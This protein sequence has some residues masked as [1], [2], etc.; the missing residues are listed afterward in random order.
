[1]R[2]IILASLLAS[3]AFFAVGTTPSQA[4]DYPWCERTLNNGGTPQCRYTSFQQCQATVSGQAGDC[5]LNPFLAY[6]EQ[7]SPRGRS[8][9]QRDRD[10]RFY[11]PRW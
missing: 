5:V 7:R 3:A 9:R 11:D 6:G 4:R 1:M 10:D 8:Y 2:S